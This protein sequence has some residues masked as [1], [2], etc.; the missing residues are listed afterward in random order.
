M[1]SQQS[2][3]LWT[4][5]DITTAA[6]YDFS[7]NGTITLATTQITQITDKSGNSRTAS[8]GDSA[9]RPTIQTSVQNGLDVARFDGSDDYLICS[10]SSSI[11]QNVGSFSIFYVISKSGG[12]DSGFA[13]WVSADTA[14][15]RAAGY[16]NTTAGVPRAAGRRL[17]GDG[18]QSHDGPTASGW[19]V[20]SAEFDYSNAELYVGSNGTVSARGGFQTAGNTSNTAS[21]AVR[22]GTENLTFYYT[23]D[24]GEIVVTQSILATSDRQKMEGYMA[25]KWGLESSL[26]GGHPYKSLPPT[27]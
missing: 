23:G 6:W 17:D 21:T 13:Y 8:Q 15:T 14:I 1:S 19:L 20:A 3:N 12:S 2:A 18:Q 26:P 22:I 27:V 25:H 24:I 16:Y 4:P 10:N 9:N 11:A 5:A 7:D